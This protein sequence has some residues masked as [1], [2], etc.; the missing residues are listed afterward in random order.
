MGRV[1]PTSTAISGQ[2]TE[3]GDAGPP[4]VF[5]VVRLDGGTG[6]RRWVYHARGT[7]GGG[8]AR[9]L[10]L[11]PG[12]RVIAAGSTAGTITCED[13][14]IVALDGTTGDVLWSQT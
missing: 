11:V 8:F 6:D 4:R 12:G 1:H 3:A 7:A 9:Q 13:G 5:T 2:S 10:Q 14:F